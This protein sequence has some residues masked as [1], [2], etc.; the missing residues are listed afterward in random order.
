MVPV[1]T[2]DFDAIFSQEGKTC[3]AHCPELDVPSC[4]HNVDEARR[5]LRTAVRLFLE[6]AEKIGTLGDILREAG[7]QQQ[8]LSAT[9]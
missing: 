9:A 8:P 3:V 5:N 2:L 1:G 7:C 4:G 6:E